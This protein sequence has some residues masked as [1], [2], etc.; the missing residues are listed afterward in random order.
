MSRPRVPQLPELAL[1]LRGPCLAPSG[2]H[3]VPVIP[4]QAARSSSKP[5]S[6]S[7]LLRLQA[8]DSWG[9]GE[10]FSRGP[11]SSPAEYL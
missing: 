7:L 2:P 5:F 3:S 4:L 9:A 11:K 1:I 10:V 8:K 6:G